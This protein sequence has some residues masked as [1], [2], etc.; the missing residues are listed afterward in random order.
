MWCHTYHSY[1]KRLIFNFPLGGV[2]HKTRTHKQ[3]TTKPSSLVMASRHF[4][5]VL[6]RQTEGF[7]RQTPECDLCCCLCLGSA[8][9]ELLPLRLMPDSGVLMLGCL[10]Q[11]RW[12]QRNTVAQMDM[13][14]GLN[15]S[16]SRIGGMARVRKACKCFLPL[17][18]HVSPFLV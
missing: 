10:L 8:E 4:P 18:Y 13:S 12:A 15:T 14:L 11:C 2:L 3:P 1:I 9:L 5:A 16:N 6:E 7:T 17:M